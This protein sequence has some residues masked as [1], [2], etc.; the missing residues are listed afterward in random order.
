MAVDNFLC[1][2]I[3]NILYIQRTQGDSDGSGRLPLQIGRHFAS[4]LSL[5]NLPTNLRTN[6]HQFSLFFK[7]NREFFLRTNLRTNKHQISLFFKERYLQICKWYSV[8]FK[9]FF[10]KWYSV[11][12]KLQRKILAKF[13]TKLS[14]TKH[15]I[16]FLYI[17]LTCQRS[18]VLQP[19]FSHKK[20]SSVLFF[21]IVFLAKT[22]VLCLVVSRL[23]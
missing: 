2:L 4:T 21:N 20:M 22:K 6:K 14:T 5:A 8:Q 7:K 13:K 10:K 9:L 17:F 1:R 3:E 19:R 18:S 12:F 11:Q 15:Q 23:N 16:K